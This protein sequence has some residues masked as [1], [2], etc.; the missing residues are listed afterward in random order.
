M[1]QRIA[2]VR[3]A[4]AEW[5]RHGRAADW[6]VHAGERLSAAEEARRF[7]RLLEDRDQEHLSACR[8]RD[9]DERA[10]A[11]WRLERERE[12]ARPRWLAAGLAVALVAAA[13]V[14]WI[15]LG[16][17]ALRQRNAA[18]A[19][20]AATDVPEGVRRA[21]DGRRSEALPFLASSLR[22]SGGA[23]TRTA[24]FALLVAVRWPTG[25]MPHQGRVI[26]ASFSADGTR[27][28]TASDDRTARIWDVDVRPPG[29]SEMELVA[30]AAEV[31][32]RYTV[33][34]GR[35]LVAL[36]DQHRRPASRQ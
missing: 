19:A 11:L 22:L 16:W 7:D 2:A 14:G 31:P 21:E 13:L 20:L 27:V 8:K 6:L 10:E 24:L 33:T 3:R 25:V 30:E 4:A 15:A 5:T 36:P 26:S 28:V 23:A 9:D 12:Q 18:S 1:L 32:S 35:N 29:G 34:E 17:M